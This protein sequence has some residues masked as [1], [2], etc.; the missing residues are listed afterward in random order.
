MKRLPKKIFKFCV[1]AGLIAALLVLIFDLTVVF[2]SKPYMYSKEDISSVA[3]FDQLQ[4]T[5]VPRAFRP[6]TCPDDQASGR[7]GRS[8]IE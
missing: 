3:D 7:A 5:D 2:T 1:I 6:L 8:S 4:D